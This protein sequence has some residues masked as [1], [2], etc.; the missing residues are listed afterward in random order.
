MLHTPCSLV[1]SIST[2]SSALLLILA[3]LLSASAIAKAQAGKTPYGPNPITL[4]RVN[5]GTPPPLGSHSGKNGP[6][7]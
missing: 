3:A 7:R 6:T 5:Q 1:S 4:D 2:R